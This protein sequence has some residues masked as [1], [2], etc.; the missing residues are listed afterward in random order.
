MIEAMGS[1]KAK[2]IRAFLSNERGILIIAGITGTL[3]LLIGIILILRT[4]EINI[5]YSESQLSEVWNPKTSE[6]KTPRETLPKGLYTVKINYSSDFEVTAE[7]LYTAKSHKTAYS[8]TPV[9]SPYSNE[10]S[11]TVWANDELEGF[12]VLT[13]PVSEEGSFYQIESI[14]IKT[15]GNSY[16]YRIVCLLISLL[17]VYALIL[18]FINLDALKKY[19]MQILGLGVIVFIA[20]IPLF[21]RFVLK[22]H[23]LNFHLMRIEGLKDALLI[24]DIPVKVQSNW[25]FGYGYAVSAMYGDVTLLLPAFMRI[26]GFTIQTS[27]KTFVFVINLVTALSSY[28]C[29]IRM[30]KGKTSIALLATFLYTCAP[31]RFC[32][33]YIRGALGEYSGMMFMPL[34]FLWMY[35]LYTG[36]IE[37]ESLAKKYI[38]PVMGFTAIL[39][40]HILTCFMISIFMGIFMLVF[41][42]KTFRKKMLIHMLKVAGLTLLVN[43]W[44]LIPFITFL[45][46]PLRLHVDN[47]YNTD[48]QIYGL[49][50]AELFAQHSSGTSY[51]NWAF[52]TN[53]GD[54]MSMP[55]GNGFVILLLCYA[56]IL[57]SRKPSAKDIAPGILGLLGI[58]SAFMATNLFPY[59]FIERT[60]PFISKFI[61]RVN[62]PY[63]YITTA[64]AILSMFSIFFFRTAQM[65]IEK[66]YLTIIFVVTLVISADQ[67]VEYLYKTMYNG[68]VKLYYDEN[69]LDTND[70][71]GYEYLYQGTNYR[72]IQQ[73]NYITMENVS[74]DNVERKANRFS[75]SGIHTGSDA[76]LELPLFYYPGYTAKSDDGTSLQIIRGNNNRLR[77]LFDNGFS[78]NIYVRY[79]EPVLWRICEMISLLSFIAVIVLEIRRRKLPAGR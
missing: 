11:F 37:D 2:R 61:T 49:S 51:Y 31:Y 39:Q 30:S 5:S 32:C 63:R 76:K 35:E 21:T 70:L 34:I 17:S 50:L 46:E 67:S 36:D 23:D 53:L 78:G 71:V 20:S 33:I 22:G 62:I 64:V 25:C 19:S 28:F 38:L 29:F 73:E 15:A 7:V 27:Y 45:K 10:I 3:L 4:E 12:R 75:I 59:D 42:R 65:D 13:S 26:L 69:V 8:E 6:Y 54:R 55:L 44:F 79:T 58:L 1:K 40:T 77:I 9:L 68:P 74:F 60:L 57:W 52:F 43:L 66:R 16:I 48:F 14:S 18:L 47:G 24:G 41:W 72:R 56:Y